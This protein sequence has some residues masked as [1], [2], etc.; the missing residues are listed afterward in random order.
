MR[1]R[2]LQA[3]LLDTLPP[4]DAGDAAG[5]GKALAAALQRHRK[6]WGGTEKRR[7][8]RH[9]WVS[10]PLTAVAALA[11]DRGLRFDVE[12]DY[13]PTS[14]VRGDLFRAPA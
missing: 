12:S 13:T 1:I 14:W 10:W 9:G 4:L 6:Y 3:P 8:D 5:F 11:W 7:Q 2:E